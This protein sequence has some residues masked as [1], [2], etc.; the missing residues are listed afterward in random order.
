VNI[1]RGRNYLEIDVD[2][3]AH[4]SYLAQRGIAWGM[5]QSEKLD[6]ALAFLI[7]VG[8]KGVEGEGVANIYI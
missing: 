5:G 8:T 1:I 4:F 7:E 2:M 6:L 3:A